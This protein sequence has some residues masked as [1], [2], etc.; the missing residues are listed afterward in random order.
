MPTMSSGESDEK[1]SIGGTER[2]ILKK[3]NLRAKR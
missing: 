2:D 1:T 3:L